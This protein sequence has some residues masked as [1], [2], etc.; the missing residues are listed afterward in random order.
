MEKTRCDPRAKSHGKRPPSVQR[1]RRK[2]TTHKSANIM[3]ACFA[4]SWRRE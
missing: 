3:H 2:Q 4:K 1:W